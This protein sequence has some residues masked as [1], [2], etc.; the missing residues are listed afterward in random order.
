MTSERLEIQTKQRV[1]AVKK[2]TVLVIVYDIRVAGC[3]LR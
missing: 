3:S 2:A 1:M